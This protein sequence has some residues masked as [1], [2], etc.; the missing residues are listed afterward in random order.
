MIFRVVYFLMCFSLMAFSK[1]PSEVLKDLKK[2]GFGKNHPKIISLEILIKQGVS[3]ND[4]RLLEFENLLRDLENQA[5]ED[6]Q[7]EG[8]YLTDL[9]GKKIQARS[10]YVKPRKQLNKQ[11][12]EKMMEALYKE[13]LKPK[14]REK[15]FI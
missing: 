11:E 4:K 12:E 5:N 15:T 2:Y 10:M 8:D 13:L 6:E 3:K 7:K 1:E 14:I 9:Y